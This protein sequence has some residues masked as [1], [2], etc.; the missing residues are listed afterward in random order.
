MFCQKC[1][2]KINDGARF[3]PGCGAPVQSQPGAA[4]SQMQSTNNRPYASGSARK[5]INLSNDRMKKL[6]PI[7]AA[8]VVVIIVLIVVIC[9]VSNS[10]K[11]FKVEDYLEVTF[12]GEDGEGYISDISGKYGWEDEAYAYLAK[13]Y[14]NDLGT[15]FELEWYIDEIYVYIDAE[16]YEGLSNGDTVTITITVED[17]SYGLLPFKV[18]GGTM[19]VKV[20]GL[21]EDV[22]EDYD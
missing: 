19:K 13:K 10:K 14:K 2:S 16:P 5:K 8:A 22:I 9:S 4:P 15:L 17:E 21:G 18:K 20:K 11:T 1:G 12:A 7:A 3:C 6:I